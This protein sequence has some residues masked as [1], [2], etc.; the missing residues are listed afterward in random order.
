M[1]FRLIGLTR[2]E[3][4]KMFRS[5]LAYFFLACSTGIILLWGVSADLFLQDPSR[6]GTGYYFLLTSVQTAMSFLGVILILIFGALLV[7]AETAAGTLQMNLVNPIS[8]L[9][10]LA[11]KLIA[12]WLFGLL[13]LVSMALP[14]LIIG[15]LKFG[16]GNYT[17]EGLTLFTRARI[18]TAILFCFLLL[19]I[20]LLAFV[21]YSLLVSVLMANVGSAIGLSVGSVL[22]LDLIRDRLRISPYLFQAYIETPFDLVKSL[23]EGFNISW[24][25]DIYLCIGVPFAWSVACFAAA[26]LIFSRK[27]YK[28]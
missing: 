27:D 26:F 2:N 4:F 21:S 6:P 10:F 20:I 15:G 1:S 13:L 22:F 3:M 25:P 14:A 19:L 16:Y 9:E 23:T 28:S 17:E 5:K 24:K 8:R 18:F 11:S 7:S 12:G